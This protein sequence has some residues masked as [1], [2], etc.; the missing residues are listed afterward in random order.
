LVINV[1]YFV[2]DLVTDLV[3]KIVTDLTIV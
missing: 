1:F 3:I 2:T